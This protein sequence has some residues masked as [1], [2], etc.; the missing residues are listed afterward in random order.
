METVCFSLEPTVFDSLIGT[1]ITFRNRLFFMIFRPRLTEL[2]LKCS[3][4]G[5]GAFKE[6]PLFADPNLK[7]APSPLL[8]TRKRFLFLNYLVRL[9]HRSY[10]GRVGAMK[11]SLLLEEG[12]INMMVVQKSANNL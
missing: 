4:G 10:C 2:F 8:F 12:K 1:P 11:N 9:L 7:T 3:F 6:K 5:A